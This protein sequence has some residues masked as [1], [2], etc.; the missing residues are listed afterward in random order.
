MN[1]S[2]IFEVMKIEHHCLDTC[3]C[4][5]CSEERERRSISSNPTKSSIRKLSVEAAYTLGY[6]SKRCSAGSLV[7]ELNQRGK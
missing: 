1:T 5:A 2:N 6:I 3:P 4:S 7:S